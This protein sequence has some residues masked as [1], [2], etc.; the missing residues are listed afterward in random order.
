MKKTHK[1]KRVPSNSR[2]IAP[3]SAKKMKENRGGGAIDLEK[4][5]FLTP[6]KK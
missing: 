4:N 5:E 2:S 1:K 3:L 6:L